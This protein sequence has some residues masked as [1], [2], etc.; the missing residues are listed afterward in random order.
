[1]IFA[2]LGTKNHCVGEASSTLK[3]SQSLSQSV[4]QSISRQSLMSFLS[5]V[6]DQLSDGRRQATTKAEE[7]IVGT[8]YQATTNEDTQLSVYCSEN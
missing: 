4:S 1:M 5:T 7:D 2:G 6:E 8:R 3:V